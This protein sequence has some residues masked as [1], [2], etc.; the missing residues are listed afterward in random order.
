MAGRT[1]WKLSRR[2]FLKAGATAAAAVFVPTAVRGASPVTI[3][4]QDFVTPRDGTPRGDAL[5]H[6]LDD[7]AA[8]YPN[9]K[10]DVKVLPSTETSTSLMNDFA[11][12]RTP[13][14]VKVY[15]PE[16]ANL[17]NAG[18][19]EPLDS[20]VSRWNKNDWLISWDSTVIDG[21][22]FSIPWDYRCNV[23]IYRKKTLVDHGANVPSTW[24]ELLVAA[25]KVGPDNPTG[26]EVGLSKTDQAS[27]FTEWFSVAVLSQGA[28][29]LN[30]DG[31]AN[32]NGP[33][34]VQAFQWLNDLFAE[35]GTSKDAID[36]TYFSIGN[37]LVAG[38]IAMA[39]MGS[40]R[41]RDTQSKAKGGAEDVGFAPPPGWDA[42]HPGQSNAVSQTLAIGRLSQYKDEA[43]T[44]I[45]FMTGPKAA[46]WRAK[47]GEVPPRKSSYN[48][49]FFKTPEAA[50]VSSF[51]D[52]LLSRPAYIHYYPKTFFELGQ[53]LTEAAQSM[54]L[55]KQ[56]P[57]AVLDAGAAK[58]NAVA[59]KS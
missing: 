16:L 5:G 40:Q 17:A 58:Y 34:G 13:D 59:K 56:A 37:G 54:V 21:K 41:V 45:D 50:L 24:P 39:L 42:K 53:A 29:P 43:M 32:I 33:A 47:G 12:R 9:I 3:T 49:P 30:P 14:V 35:G 11:A 6:N 19:V 27:I 46:V 20:Y 2:R 26:Y 8:A 28:Q 7:F 51:K 31:T 23:L 4:Y 22:K 36:G 48:D 25:K 1:A 15:L 57:K 55:Q 52:I 38:T 10:V 18:I 44:F